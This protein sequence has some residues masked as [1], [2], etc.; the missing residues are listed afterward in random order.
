MDGKQDIFLIEQDGNSI[1]VKF[2]H[3]AVD[4]SIYG[5]IKTEDGAKTVMDY[6][7]DPALFRQ[8]LSWLQ[9]EFIQALR[10]I[11]NEITNKTSALDM[12]QQSIFI[13]YLR[14]FSGTHPGNHTKD[15]IEP[16]CTYS[17]QQYDPDAKSF[18]FTISQAAPLENKNK[19]I[20]VTK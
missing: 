14:A 1:P 7:L 19:F 11:N 10:D 3:R 20:S 6:F 15:T 5:D 16:K 4:G 18:S 12:A 8:N 17:Q 2:Q 9:Q 13:T